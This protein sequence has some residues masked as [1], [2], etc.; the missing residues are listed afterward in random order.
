MFCFQLGEK[1]SGFQPFKS[2]A[3]EFY[4]IRDKCLEKGQLFEDP[5]FGA[6][7]KSLFFKNKPERRLE[8]KRPKVSFSESLSF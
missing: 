4:K 2:G 5:E 8:W 7:D 3:Q 1:G 6:C